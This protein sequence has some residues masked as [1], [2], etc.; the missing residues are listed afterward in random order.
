MPEQLQVFKYTELGTQSTYVIRSE[1]T[2][3]LNP[4]SK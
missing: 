4:H 1:N 2:K 3:P